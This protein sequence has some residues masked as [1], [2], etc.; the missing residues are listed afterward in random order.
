M[1]SRKTVKRFL[2]L[3]LST[4]A[5]FLLSACSSEQFI[6]LNPKGPV[7][8]VQANL[9]FVSFLVLMIVIIPVL[10][11]FFFIVYRYRDKPGNKSPYKPEWDDNVKLEVVWWGIPIILIAILSILTVRDTLVLQGPPSEDVEPITIQVTSLDWKWLFQY[12]EEDIA[13]VNYLKIP[14]DTP[15]Q[16][17]L[18]SDAPINS[19]WIPQLGGQR[20]SLP[21]KSSTLWLEAEE[22]GTYYG[23]ANN[24]SGDGFTEM[25]FD[26]STV[27]DAD[28]DKWVEE[29]K[30]TNQPFT[31]EDYQE[32]VK[33]SIVGVSA[34]SSIPPNLFEFIVDKNGGKYYKSNNH[35]EQFDNSRQLEL[36]N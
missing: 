16:F 21:G 6:V 18:T 24:F 2:M 23:T 19:F 26:V 3:I 27:P 5:V 28:F 12:P 15:V 11:L 32:L 4:F 22:A 36:G 1:P 10:L 9:I 34:Y 30:A 31:M 14:V 25:N 29:V 17:E 8:E 33:P 13:T 20:Y 7:G 35:T